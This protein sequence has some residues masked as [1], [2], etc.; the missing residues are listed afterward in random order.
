MANNRMYLGCKLC[1]EMFYLAKYYPF[2]WFRSSLMPG[3]EAEKKLINTSMGKKF[4]KFMDDHSEHDNE[5]IQEVGEEIFELIYENNPK[6][7]IDHSNYPLT[8]EPWT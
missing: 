6:V 5:R 2:E 4:E 3:E 1:G 7:I 8:Y